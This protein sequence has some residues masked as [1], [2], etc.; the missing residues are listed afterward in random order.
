LKELGAGNTLHLYAV[1]NSLPRASI[2][3]VE[4][5]QFMDEQQILERVGDRHFDLAGNL[6]LPTDAA[7]PTDAPAPTE[8][9]GIAYQ[10]PRADEI[11]VRLTSPFSG[12]L[13]LIETWDPG[14]RAT[15][16]GKPAPVVPAYTTFV[17]VPIS[18]GR[19][20]IRLTYH[21]PGVV[22]GWV[23]SSLSL[24]G[25]VGLCWMHRRQRHSG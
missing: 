10:R 6:L 24:F 5:A 20:E 17:A 22:T 25:L 21:T 15:V 19:H 11:V 8:T 3:P 16:D 4:R 9:P 18:P 12:Y 7:R 2:M 13:R 1:P 14:W 23:M